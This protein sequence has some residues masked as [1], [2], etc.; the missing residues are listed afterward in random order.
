M[1][2]MKEVCIQI[3]NANDGIP[4]GM[5]IED[6]VRMKELEIYNWQEYEREK[7]RRRVKFIESEN[8]GET[9]KVEQVSKKFSSF[10]GEAREEKGGE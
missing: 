1:G 6:V 8:S 10:Y 5:T 2:R 9:G 7:E 4:E 3:M